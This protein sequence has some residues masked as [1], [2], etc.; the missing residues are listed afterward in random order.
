MWP[1]NRA[2][3]SRVSRSARAASRRHR[4]RRLPLEIRLGTFCHCYRQTRCNA[5]SASRSSSSSDALSPCASCRSLDKMI[6]HPHCRRDRSVA[7]SSECDKRPTMPFSAAAPAMSIWRCHV[8]AGRSSDHRPICLAHCVERCPDL[9]LGACQ[10]KHGGFGIGESLMAI[11]GDSRRDDRPA[12]RTLRL[13]P[14]L[15]T[16]PLPD[17]DKLAA[18]WILPADPGTRFAEELVI[19][20]VGKGIVGV[21]GFFVGLLFR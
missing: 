9:D 13:D 14:E 16:E 8:M 17:L 21:I 19:H 6:S 20:V 4:T 11:L 7:A 15:S 3:S 18:V 1:I 12:G 5:A 10:L 2:A